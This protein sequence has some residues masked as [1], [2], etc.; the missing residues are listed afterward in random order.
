VTT[1]DIPALRKVGGAVIQAAPDFQAAHAARAAQ[2]VPGAPGAW[3]STA[4]ISNAANAW[5][6]FLRQLTGQV[7]TLGADLTRTAG[8]FEAADL[9]AA[10]R[11]GD[12]PAG[13][14]AL[15]RA[16]GYAR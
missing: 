10:E 9:R 8:E 3:S 13:H 4:A 11:N 2:L 5:G 12:I 14:P 6:A 7:N 16:H 15:G 1:V